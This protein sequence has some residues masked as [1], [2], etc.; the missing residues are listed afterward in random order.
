[1]SAEPLHLVADAAD[2]QYRIVVHGG[3]SGGINSAMH[4]VVITTKQQMFI[5]GII[6]SIYQPEAAARSRQ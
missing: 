6:Y 3:A 2:L 5:W 4:V 1:M